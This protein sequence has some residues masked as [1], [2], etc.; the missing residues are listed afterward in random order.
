MNWKKT[1]VGLLL[2]VVLLAGCSQNNSLK[3]ERGVTVTGAEG[4]SSD[5]AVILHFA[6]FNKVGPD[7]VRTSRAESQFICCDKNG[8]VTDSFCIN[9]EVLANPVVSL[10]SSVSIGFEDYSLICSSEGIDYLDNSL[11]LDLS[12]A[13]VQC[14]VLSGYIEEDDTAY[15]VFNMGTGPIRGQYTTILRFVNPQTSYDVVIPHS[16]T[17]VAYDSSNRQ[18]VYR[19]RTTKNDF[20]YGYIDYDVINKKY[21][22]NPPQAPI[23]IESSISKF[24]SDAVGSLR[25][26]YADDVIYEIIKIYLNEEVVKDLNL[27]SDYLDFSEYKWG[28]LVLRTIDLKDKTIELK[29]LT[30]E[31]IAGDL[32]YGLVMFGTEQ[33]PAYAA[34]G[35]LYYFTCDEKLNIYDPQCG[36]ARYDIKFDTTD[37]LDPEE[38]FSENSQGGPTLGDGSPVKIF[39]DGSMYT[40]HV[41]SDG[42]FKIHKYNFT[43]QCF[44]LYWTSVPGIL[45]MLDK[46]SLLFCSFELIQ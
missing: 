21:N 6:T 45:D 34:N 42:S 11:S 19:V 31:P 9:R 46:Q 2:C 13:T 3:F 36:F 33:M 30:P 41:Y 15:Y 25:A 1:F 16:L 18:F 27:S 8:A 37:T 44:E 22:Y 4:I 32:R 7:F 43:E 40:A 24:G 28:V 5:S 20:V 10:S 14:P 17:F 35:K 23:S 39:N 12:D 29:Y 38:L 26:L